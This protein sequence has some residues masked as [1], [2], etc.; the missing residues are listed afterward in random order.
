MERGISFK[1]ASRANRFT[2]AP[3]RREPPR[4][5]VSPK[6][7]GFCLACVLA[8]ALIPPLFLTAAAVPLPPPESTR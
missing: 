4:N 7:T 5:P 3:S 1:L 6:D 8:L 2:P